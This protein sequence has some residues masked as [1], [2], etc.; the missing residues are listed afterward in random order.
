[1]KKTN[2]VSTVLRRTILDEGIPSAE[3]VDMAIASGSLTAGGVDPLAR[4]VGL[5]ADWNHELN[6]E[7]G[8]GFRFSLS[9]RG[10]LY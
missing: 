4:G 8:L 1:V 7:I 3:T 2:P 10:V 5:R 9:N 6:W